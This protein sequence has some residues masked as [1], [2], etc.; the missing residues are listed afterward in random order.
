MND[1]SLQAESNKERH[2]SFL[3]I[4]EDI[5][6]MDNS[7]DLQN[8]I[9]IFGGVNEIFYFYYSNTSYSILSYL[10]CGDIRILHKRR[11]YDSIYQYVSFFLSNFK[12]DLNVC[13]RCG[14]GCG[15]F[16]YHSLITLL[17][18]FYPEEQFI[19]FCELFLKYEDS[20]NTIASTSRF[21]KGL[22]KTDDTETNENKCLCMLEADDDGYEEVNI[23]VPYP[24]YGMHILM[25]IGDKNIEIKNYIL[26]KLDEYP[27]VKQFYDY[28]EMCRKH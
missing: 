25:Y 14:E 2:K 24:N 9:D 11:D 3:S 13:V 19:R 10:L 18:S 16:T 22:V 1:S 12:P 20:V 15:H 21:L 17:C 23:D 7:A 8:K 4:I 5:K 28:V 27:D 6:T 26:R